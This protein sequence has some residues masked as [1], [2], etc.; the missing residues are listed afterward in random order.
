MLI[1]E[2]LLV[3]LVGSFFGWIFETIRFFAV[4]RKLTNRGFLK[5]IYLPIYGFGAVS[6]LLI[7]YLGLNLFYK[8]LLFLFS[9][10]LLEF[11]VGIFFLK[12][13]IRL[14][15][16]NWSYN[17]KG[18]VSIYSSVLWLI[19][20]WAFYYFIFPEIGI[21][22]EILF[23][24]LIIRIFVFLVYLTMLIDF[25]TR[26]RRLFFKTPKSS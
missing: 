14:W 10:T 1:Q 23:E 3:F 6:V 8:S 12:K 26:I 4:N 2:V 22:T 20:A 11:V 16:Y 13:G 21:L 18:I 9:I 7:S 17:Y 24:H 19:F 25:F 5:G 15:E